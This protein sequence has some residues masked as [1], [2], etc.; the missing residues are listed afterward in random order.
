MIGSPNCSSLSSNVYIKSRLCGL[1]EAG[2]S[3]IMEAN[4]EF[5]PTS[6]K[7]VGWPGTKKNNIYLCISAHMLNFF[8]KPTMVFVGNNYTC[9]FMWCENN[10]GSSG[11]IKPKYFILFSI[12]IIDHRYCDFL[13]TLSRLEFYGLKYWNI[14]I[15]WI[16][17]I[18]IEKYIV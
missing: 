13:L 11:E 16:E 15:V 1:V 8:L 10:S 18:R 7:F 5:N 3:H 14:V 4:E 9:P 12:L 6:C 17:V 2:A